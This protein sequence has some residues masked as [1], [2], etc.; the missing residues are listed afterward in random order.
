MDRG[1]ND[2]VSLEMASRVAAR[3]AKDPALVEHARQ[4]LA[5]WSARNHDA[6]GL[7]RC[8]REWEE[9][10]RRPVPEI[11]EIL[12][13]QGDENRRLR[14]NSPFTGIL[15]VQEVRDIKAQL[16]HDPRAA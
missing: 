14:S 16:R 13:G 1:Y 15:S 6:P 5:R 3:L 11:I 9:I 10:L 12:T 4:N 7:L 2:R 8:Y